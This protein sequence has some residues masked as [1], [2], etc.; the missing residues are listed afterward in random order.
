VAETHGNNYLTDAQA[1]ARHSHP[2]TD[3][4]P[5]TET[6]ALGNSHAKTQAISHAESKAATFSHTKVNPDSHAIGYADFHTGFG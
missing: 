5:D 6:K 2:A 4:E 1:P 3:S